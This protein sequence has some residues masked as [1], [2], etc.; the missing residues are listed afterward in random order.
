MRAGI[1]LVRSDGDQKITA[2]EHWRCAKQRIRRGN[3]GDREFAVRQSDLARAVV[4]VVLHGERLQNRA[5]ERA[6][7]RQVVGRCLE[8][9][10]AAAGTAGVL[11]S[12]KRVA[13]ILEGVLGARDLPFEA[14][15]G[16]KTCATPEFEQVRQAEQVLGNCDHRRL[17]IDIG[18]DC[19]SAEAKTVFRQD[20]A[21]RHVDDDGYF[22]PLQHRC[23]R[24][25]RIA[26]RELLEHGVREAKPNP[27]RSVEPAA[28]VALDAGR[29]RRILVVDFYLLT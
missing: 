4:I 12:R 10:V 3:V 11:E 8:L 7:Y 14:E 23:D 17:R 19:R 22:Q 28:F 16:A 9:G 20:R 1:A 27:R 15:P 29:D 21:V 2:R 5:E 26:D 18:S 24:R 25:V 13:Q 6:L